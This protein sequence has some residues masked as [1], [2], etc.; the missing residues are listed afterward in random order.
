MQLTVGNLIR[1][2]K[3]VAEEAQSDRAYAGE[4]L[5]F[6]GGRNFPLTVI[7]LDCSWVAP[8]IPTSHSLQNLCEK[9]SRGVN[10]KKKKNP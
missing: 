3:V 5:V 9:H 10:E 8:C 7:N 6:S 4:T 1:K 2:R